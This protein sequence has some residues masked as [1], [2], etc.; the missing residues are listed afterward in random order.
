M[1]HDLKIDRYE[2]MEELGVYDYFRQLQKQGKIKHFGH[3]SHENIE[4][5]TKIV[6]ER[7]WD[8]VMLHLNYMDTDNLKLYELA[9]QK[10]I[11][12]FAME[13]VKGGSLSN[14]PDDIL[15]KLTQ[16]NPGASVSSWGVRWAGSL[17]SPG[18][19]KSSESLFGIKVILSGMSDMAQV[20]DNLKTC[21]GFKP[22]SDAEYAAIE[23]VKSMLYKRVRNN[24]TRCDYCMPCPAGVNIPWMF[25][26]WNNYGIYENK[27][28][29]NWEWSITAEEC[30]AFNCTGCGK[31]NELCPQRI[32]VMGDLKK[33]TQT[34]NEIK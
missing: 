7:E 19:L 33:V 13:T 18:S 15:A 30:R 23:E 32:D 20:E 17:K 16:V 9:V 10:N 29:S 11:P 26:I 1:L 4:N 2:K 6:N 31:C 8:F 22:L 28:H 24:C 12:V 3:S 14:F 5:F 27:G 21:T 34:M 25:S